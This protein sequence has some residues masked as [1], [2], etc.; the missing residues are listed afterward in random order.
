MIHI[1]IFHIK[2]RQNKETFLKIKERE[3]Y[4]KQRRQKKK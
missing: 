1:Q 2:K 3:N 4:I